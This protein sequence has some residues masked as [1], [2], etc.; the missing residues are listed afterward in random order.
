M[1]CCR[2]DRVTREP[3]LERGGLRVLIVEDEAFIA[4]ELECLLEEAGYVP[5]GVA[6]RSGDAIALAHDLSPTS[7]SSTS[8]SPT[9]RPASRWRRR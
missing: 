5:V 3:V 6:I 1:S 7:P 9:A 8:T 4:L 2:W